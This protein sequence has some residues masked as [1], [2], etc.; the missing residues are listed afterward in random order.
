MALQK[1]RECGRDISTV[2]K[3]CPIC[4]APV[5]KP[6]GVFL[7]LGCL[8]IVGL[9][10]FFLCLGLINRERDPSGRGRKPAGRAVPNNPPQ[11]AQPNPAPQ[12]A[13]A[14]ARE[15]VTPA[16]VPREKKPEPRLPPYK[17]A[18][19]ETDRRNK[20]IVVQLESNEVAEAE[21]RQIALK[22]KSEDSRTYDN[23]MIFY[24][25]PRWD[26]GGFAWA[27]SHFN[28]NL[29]VEINGL[30]AE[31]ERKL[32]EIPDAEWKGAIG[33]WLEE[34]VGNEARIVIRRRGKSLEITRV[35][36]DGTK[37]SDAI[38]ER[39][40]GG[41]RRFDTRE[42]SS[43]DDHFVIDSHGDLEIRDMMGLV[44]VA[45]KIKRKRPEKPADGE[46]PDADDASVDK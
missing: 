34:A 16:E 24:M 33:A 46:R 25:Q 42:K 20:R 3:A 35:F 6:G 26:L 40:V 39:R 28:P 37:S 13:Q 38:V 1:C 32:T 4:G 10:G 17:I 30:S 21:L 45:K 2:V 44:R 22:L 36:R 27:T 31:Q 43:T 8:S 9:F 29:R 11:A 41:R 14:P 19:S 12:A 23:I 7:K 18:K 15:P 5:K